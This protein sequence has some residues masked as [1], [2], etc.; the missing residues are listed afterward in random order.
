MS[1][2]RMLGFVLLI[3]GVVLI[4]YSLYS[5]Y[6][7]FTGSRDA[8][9][10]FPDT[11]EKSAEVLGDLGE[12]EAQMEELLQRQLEGILPAETIPKSLNLFAW[13]IFT[14]ILIFGGAQLAGIGVKLLKK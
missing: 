2:E 10:I 11:S 9:E 4:L 1:I 13:S 12:A 3:V 5:S 14:G 7:I 8:P 6:G